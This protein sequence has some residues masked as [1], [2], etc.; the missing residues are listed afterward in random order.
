MTANDLSIF[1]H[2]AGKKKSTRNIT[3]SFVLNGRRAPKQNF[4]DK[5]RKMGKFSASKR[6]KIWLKFVK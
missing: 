3:Y 2:I 4:V 5:N 6:P 1:Q